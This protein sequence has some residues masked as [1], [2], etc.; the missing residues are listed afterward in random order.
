MNYVKDTHISFFLKN[1]SVTTHPITSYKKH[2]KNILLENVPGINFAKRGPKP[3]IVFS[4]VTKEKLKTQMHEDFRV[5]DEMEAVLKASQI[6]RREITETVEW[7]FTG[8]FVDFNTPMKLQQFLKW[9][10]SGPH[11]H[12]SVTRETEIEKSSRNLAQQIISSFRQGNSFLECDMSNLV[13]FAVTPDNVCK[14]IEKLDKLGR[15]ALEKFVSTLMVKQSVNFWDAQKKNNWSYFK[16]VGATVQI[17]VKGQL[18]SIKQEKS[19]LSQLLFLC[20]T[21]NDFVAEDAIAEFEFSV[22]PPSNFHPDRSMIMLSDKSKLV[23]AVMNIPLPE[24]PAISEPES[25]APSVLII[26]SMCMVNIV[27][28]TLKCQMPCTLQRSLLTLWL[29]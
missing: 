17:K 5:L 1:K 15:E 11:M 3:E 10:I 29:T 2:I 26:D 22:A 25:D 27:P 28:K 7:Q 18:V 20:K 14:N 21:R 23:S 19:L 8:S 24:D 13:T 9:V 16:D 4:T 12:L 6:I